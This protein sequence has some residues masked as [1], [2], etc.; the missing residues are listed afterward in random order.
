MVSPLHTCAV[1]VTHCVLQA[2][3]GVLPMLFCVESGT[4]RSHLQTTLESGAQMHNATQSTAGSTA[5]GSTIALQSFIFSNVAAQSFTLAPKIA[6]FR[7]PFC[8][9]PIWASPNHAGSFN[10]IC[11]LMAVRCANG[12]D[13]PGILSVLVKMLSTI[14]KEPDKEVVQNLFWEQVKCS[15]ELRRVIEN[16]CMRRNYGV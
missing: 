2:R 9:V 11:H 1:D 5:T 6:F 15:H 13:P 12:K 8:S 14:Q 4:R 7:V 10:N 16:I 3:G